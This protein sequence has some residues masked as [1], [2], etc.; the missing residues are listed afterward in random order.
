M[1]KEDL[2][3]QKVAELASAMGARD[4]ALERR[5]DELLKVEQARI[6]ETRALKAMVRS[7]IEKVG[8]QSGELTIMPHEY[9]SMKEA[10][11]A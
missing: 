11:K 7:L 2:V 5:L 4:E 3:V 1:L 9:E 6:A 10:V 8:R